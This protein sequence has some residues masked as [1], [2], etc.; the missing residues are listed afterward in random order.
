MRVDK[1]SPP[2]SLF[3]TERFHCLVVLF[4][5]QGGTP[6]RHLHKRTSSP[7]SLALPH[8]CHKGQ[9]FQ[10]SLFVTLTFKRLD[11]LPLPRFGIKRRH[12]RALGKWVRVTLYRLLGALNGFLTSTGEMWSH[13]PELNHSLKWKFV[14]FIQ[15]GKRLGHHRRNQIYWLFHLF[16]VP[17]AFSAVTA[18]LPEL[19]YNP[20][21]CCFCCPSDNKHISL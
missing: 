16:Q 17:Q 20:S 7:L 9:Y 15:V 5:H 13:P 2:P 1:N 21:I 18:Q 12:F 10:M 8:V 6:Q 3:L 19:F 4:S 11:S 14:F